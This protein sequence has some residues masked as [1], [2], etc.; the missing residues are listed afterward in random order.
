MSLEFNQEMKEMVRCVQLY[1]FKQIPQRVIA[2]ELGLS[3]SKVSR[4]LQR[5]FDEKYFRVD[6]NFPVLPQLA[7]QL[8][9]RYG[10]RDAVVVN[11]GINSEIKE[12]I[13]RA[14]AR[15]F[16]R[17]VGDGARVGISCGHTLY[18][19]T[20]HLTEGR[21]KDLKIYP[22]ASE[23]TYMSADILPNTLVGMMTAKYRPKVTAYVLPTYL[24]GDSEEAQLSE[25]EFRGSPQVKEILE[26]ARN[27][28]VALVGVG[29]V[30]PDT[31]GF[32]AVAKAG[33]IEPEQLTSLG[34]VGEFNYQPLGQ[35]GQAITDPS[36]GGFAQRLGAVS[37]DRLKEM[38][39][40]HGK[41]VIAMGGGRQKL[42]A[43]NAVL[44]GRLCNV[45]ITDQEVADDLLKA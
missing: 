9:D 7:A 37:L 31:P 20:K 28:D 26:N 18:F 32:C 19:M 24:G 3:A 11:T 36:L 15:Y 42:A 13:G 41:T 2:E 35:E 5:A 23:S 17:I 25:R 8:I 39:A 43:I 10:L 44:K 1:Y 22:L 29:C 6:L 38:S 45:L 12:D 4:L 27:V 34:A 16:E 14:A 21:I 30:D 33:G 40:E